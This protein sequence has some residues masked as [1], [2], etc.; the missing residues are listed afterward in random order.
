[1]TAGIQWHA[2]LDAVPGIRWVPP[3]AVEADPTLGRMRPRPRQDAFALPDEIE[4]ASEGTVLD[5]PWRGVTPCAHVSWRVYNAPSAAAVAQLSFQALLVP[6]TTSDYLEA[7][8]FGTT[9]LMARGNAGDVLLE[10]QEAG[11]A[12]I[13]A[14]P[15]AARGAERRTGR[16]AEQVLREPYTVAARVLLADGLTADAAAVERR[17]EAALG[18]WVGPIG[19][20]A[21]AVLDGL[22]EVWAVLR[23]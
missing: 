19:R 11:M 9:H 20:P 8:R 15:E 10:L 16:D 21:T 3:A 5:E 1:V 2:S 12:L 13:E 14:D 6:G 23:A 18:A 4:W 22:Q 7:V 17:E